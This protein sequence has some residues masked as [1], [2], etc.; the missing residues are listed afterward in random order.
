[1][2]ESAK[3][4]RKIFQKE[5]EFFSFLQNP[6]TTYLFFQIAHPFHSGGGENGARRKVFKI[7][8]NF[9]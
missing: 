3:E 6:S 4:K 2:K 9:F 5:V 7:M 8:E 1:M